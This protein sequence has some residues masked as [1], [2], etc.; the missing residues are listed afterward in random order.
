MVN[1]AKRNLFSIGALSLVMAL[2]SSQVQA[3]ESNKTPATNSRYGHMYGGGYG[4]MGNGYMGQGMMGAGGMY[5][6]GTPE[7]KVDVKETKDGAVI[8][9]IGKN[10][11]EIRRIKKMAQMM[12]LQHEMETDSE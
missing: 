9:L 2:W 3:E 12:K 4:M 1:S 7:A 6:F 8:T 5:P 11:D 10:K